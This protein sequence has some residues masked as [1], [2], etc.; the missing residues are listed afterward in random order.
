MMEFDFEAVCLGKMMH[1]C[2]HDLTHD[3]WTNTRL[4]DTSP[5]IFFVYVN[6]EIELIRNETNHMANNSNYTLTVSHPICSHGKR[7][8]SQD[9]FTVPVKRRK[10]LSVSNSSSAEVYYELCNSHA[11]M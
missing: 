7:P 11:S 5:L 10:V 6:W 4:L 8:T 3:G 9:T 1:A 2:I